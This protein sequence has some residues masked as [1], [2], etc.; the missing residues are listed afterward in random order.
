[1]SDEALAMAKIKVK[2]IEVIL[3]PITFKERSN[4]SD[5]YIIVVKKGV[6]L[7]LGAYAKGYALQKVKSYLEQQEVKSYLINGGSSSIIVGQKD[8]QKENDK[9]YKIG[10][11]NPLYVFTEKDESKIE[12]HNYYGYYY[13][14]NESITTSGTEQQYVVDKNGNRYHHLISPLTKEP[15]NFYE[16]FTLIGADAGELD[17]LS[18]AV[19]SMEPAV[20][21]EFILKKGLRGVSFNVD[22]TYSLY[23]SQTYFSKF[24]EFN[25]TEKKV[26]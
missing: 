13:I 6:K 2:D 16:G 12:A 4:D 10:L 8:K 19:F 14:K 15:A 5:P 18:T 21:N 9:Y 20:A 7:D 26:D 23:G 24:T 22:Q 17:A 1:M 11:S 25:F 3:E